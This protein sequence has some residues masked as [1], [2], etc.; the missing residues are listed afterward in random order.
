[1][2]GAD[3]V[4][5]ISDGEYVEVLEREGVEPGWAAPVSTCCGIGAGWS[6][7]LPVFGIHADPDCAGVPGIRCGGPVG[8]FVGKTEKSESVRAR[9]GGVL[10]AVLGLLRHFGAFLLKSN[11][12]L[13]LHKVTL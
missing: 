11:K 4:L 6:A 13:R 7:D 8:V 1:M 5:R 3:P 9:S 12:L 10:W 2:A